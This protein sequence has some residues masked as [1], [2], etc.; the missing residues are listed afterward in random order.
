MPSKVTQYLTGVP[1]TDCLGTEAV[2]TSIEVERRMMTHPSYIWLYLSENQL[3]LVGYFHQFHFVASHSGF[4]SIQA[5][6]VTHS[7]LVSLTS[8]LTSGRSVDTKYAVKIE[9]AQHLSKLPSWD[10]SDNS[11]MLQGFEWHVPDDQGHWKRLQRSLVS[12]KSIGVDSIWIPPGCKAMNPS[13]NGYDIY[14]LYDLGEFDQKGSRS[15]KWG[16]KT[17]LQSLACSARNLGIGICWDAVLN[18]K[19][20]ADYTERF[21][22]VKV[23]P[24]DRSVEIFAAREIE[25]WVGFS[26]P[27]R[28]GIYS[29]MKYSWQHFSGVDWDEARKKNAIYRVASKRWSDDVAHE[30]GNYDYLMF[31]D[32]DYSKLEVQKDVLRWGEWIGSQLP[33]WGMRLDASKHYSADF[34][35]KF[36]NHVRATVGPQ[37]FF[38]A[39]Y[40]SGDVRVLMHYLQ[41]M[42]YQLSLFD[43]PL[44]GRFSRISRTGEDLRKIFD[45]TLVGNKPA[46]AITLVMNHDTVRERAPIASFFKPLAYALIL[47]RDKGQPCIFYGDLYGIRRGV[48]NP[49]TP[50]CG[51]KLPVLARAR[52]L[53]AYGEQ[54]DY[55]DQA[56]CIGF[57]RY[58]NLH[59]PSGLACIMS[60]GGA[61]QKRMYVGR[62]HAKER[63]TDILGW[64]PKTVIID[65]KGYG[66]FPV[67][68]MQVSVWVNSAAEGR[69]SLQ[70]PFEEKIYEN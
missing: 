27:G 14:D 20:G 7:I 38:V 39:E 31:A 51:G 19:A 68:A 50:S 25:G 55:F 47:L 11:L 35:K 58:G 17:E 53:Y 43:A 62:S 36:V 1:H 29:S 37:I 34:Q 59:H 65:K 44:V 49:M 41:K 21:S 32:L 60:N 61:S 64:H 66:I 63:W 24:K 54:C 9:E 56:N 46:H 28:G 16:S 33:L 23:D 13:G 67:S 18:H 45:D 10:T 8:L 26:F 40:W 70:E 22:A 57:V 69:E 52:K 3:F 4:L 2:D 6:N 5:I 42:D 15:T 30:K 12:L 48:K